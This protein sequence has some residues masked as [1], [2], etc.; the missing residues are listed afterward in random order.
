MNEQRKVIYT[1]RMRV[2]DGEDLR[3]HLMDVIDSA[4]SDVVESYC[5]TPF[6][7]DW[8]LDGL[9]N[10]VK[11]YY[12]SKFELDELAEAV[13]PEQLH[14]SLVSEAVGYYEDRE[15]QYGE[16]TM[17]EVER[18]IYLQLIDQKWREH[19][20]EMDYLRDGI[21]LRAMG[22]QDPLVAWQKEGYEMFGNLVSS[23]DDD[24]VKYANHVDVVIEEPALPDLSKAHFEAADDP[25]QGLSGS[26]AAR[27]E[28]VIAAAEAQA[29]AEGDGAPIPAPEMG[30][31]G[32]GSDDTMQP[33]VKSEHD[34]VGRNDPCW[35]GSGKKYKHCHG[36]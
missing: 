34:K 15:K 3:S 4:L 30:A 22:Q 16:D 35:C 2:I 19:L 6:R 10:E 28:A 9:L 13:T 7:E 32:D 12:P 36:R 1:K 33:V 17:R 5:P 11:L 27:R 18:Q 14:Q 20:A 23:I 24:F 29:E 31:G 25:I 26:E 21:G 8:N